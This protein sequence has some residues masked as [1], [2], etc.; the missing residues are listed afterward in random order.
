M[1][2][3][4][5]DEEVDFLKE[6]YPVEGVKACAE[7]LD[8]TE[9]S[10]RIKAS[11]LKIKVINGKGTKTHEQY[12]TEVNDDIKVL[13]QYIN[14]RTK[15]LHK[16]LVCGHEWEAL[17]YNLSRGGGCPKCST[18]LKSHEEYVLQV[19]EGYEVIETYIKDG[20]KILHRHKT[21]GHEWLINPS[22]LLHGYG[23]PACQYK[24][25]K[26][27]YFIYFKD[28]D[29]YKVGVTNNYKRRLKQFGYT[30]KLISLKEYKTP[31]EAYEEEQ[32]LLSKLPLVNTGLLNSGNTETFRF[33]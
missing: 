3:M 4:W 33:S 27:L 24:N 12:C 32:Y 19:P 13:G 6:W 5:T 29:L 31:K 2:K 7:V 9:K 17:P 11:R 26:Q 22:N 15:I 30:P 14:S 20:V 8:R 16:H 28:L 18:R 23:C 25:A 21:C 1:R 10:V